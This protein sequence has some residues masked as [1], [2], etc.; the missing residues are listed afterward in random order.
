MKCRSTA[1]LFCFL[2]LLGAYGS[3]HEPL[4]ATFNEGTHTIRR[5]RVGG[6]A[7]SFPRLLAK[8][9]P[10]YPHLARQRKIQGTVIF[11]ILISAKGSV[12]SARLLSGHPL[13]VTAA[14]EAVVRWRYESPRFNGESVEVITTAAVTFTLPAV[15]SPANRPAVKTL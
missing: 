10:V 3:D 2:V 9:E 11:E 13:L 14:R 6:A 8:V 4:H 12:E 15:P 7:R 5:L 1:A